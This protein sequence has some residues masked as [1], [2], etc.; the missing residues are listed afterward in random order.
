M[1]STLEL[2]NYA[3]GMYI[4]EEED[5]VFIGPTE[6][7]KETRGKN[8]G[9]TRR[10]TYLHQSPEDESGFQEEEQEK[11]GFGPYPDPQDP[12]E[13][14][15]SS[16]SEML[17]L[18][19]M[20]GEFY[21]EEFEKL[22]YQEKKKVQDKVQVSEPKSAEELMRLYPEEEM[23]S[24]L[25]HSLQD[26]E[27]AQSLSEN[28]IQD[29]KSLSPHDQETPKDFSDWFQPMEELI[30]F[31]ILGINYREV[32]EEMTPLE[33]RELRKKVDNTEPKSKEEILAMLAE[34]ENEHEEEED[35][36][37]S[38]LD[39]SLDSPKLN[40]KQKSRRLTLLAQNQ[41]KVPEGVERTPGKVSPQE[42]VFKTPS[43]HRRNY[44]RTTPSYLRPTSASA[45]KEHS[46][47][48]S[49]KLHCP[50][51]C[52]S[53]SVSPHFGSSPK[54]SSSRRPTTGI[55]LS[56][57]V[58]PV[59]Q[60]I[61]SNPVPPLI[62]NIK[63]SPYHAKQVISEVVKETQPLQPSCCRLNDKNFI[64]LPEANYKPS[65]LFTEQEIE[66]KV[67][68]LS[69]SSFPS[70]DA[71][72]PKIFRHL[73]R[74]KVPRSIQLSKNGIENLENIIPSSSGSSCKMTLKKNVRDSI[75]TPSNESMIDMSVHE[76]KAV[77]KLSHFKA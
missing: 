12:F 3:P 31:D 18:Y 8:A 42:Y 63:P 57:V 27:L 23:D 54:Q 7:S 26:L 50:R 6:S 29:T 67:K 14:W 39:E 24:S 48:S 69:M 56:K 65:S 76:I 66:S 61:R 41:E 70:T 32:F 13:A 10:K 34:G 44:G 28:T 77:Q 46:P 47:K 19:E 71:L 62:R 51:Y 75:A 16:E 11:E 64:P 55:D 60:Y 17:I 38:E 52:E 72:E 25:N 49:E 20:F 21:D 36:Q 4:D 15:F 59:A 53:N 2:L 37:V 40:S 33:Q 43:N 1:D 45:R 73:G 5:E 22:S 30:L 35:S 74:V 58:S 68:T 9:L